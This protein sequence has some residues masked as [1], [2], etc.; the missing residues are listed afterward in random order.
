[1]KQIYYYSEK[2]YKYFELIYWYLV[3]RICLKHKSK[4]I[5]N[6]IKTNRIFLSTS[7]NF[8]TEQNYEKNDY[9]IPLHIYKKINKKI[10]NRLTYSDLV[11]VLLR[12]LKK[13]NIKYLEIGVSVLKNYM[14][15]NNQIKNATLVAYD[16]NKP[17][18][19]YKKLFNK[20]NNLNPKLK[21]S[22]T[23][24]NNLYYFQGDVLD[25]EDTSSFI[26]LLNLKYDFVM[27]DAMHTKKGIISEFDN[28][29]KNQLEEIFILYYDD[30]DFPG[31]QEAAYE[32]YVKLL[33]QD[34]NLNFYTFWISGW[35]GQH[36]KMHKNGIISNLDIETLLNKEKIRLPFFKKIS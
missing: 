5:M 9:G 32:N 15:I 19:V 2:L 28:I 22:D 1:M 31:L 17:V 4:K 6:V 29:I 35:V 10:N 36:E 14:Q 7:E 20:V 11:P 16:I 27:S 33:S 25:K 13:E 34:E 18:D 12:F 21:Y 30:L 3:S 26:T 24:D 8:L 23:A